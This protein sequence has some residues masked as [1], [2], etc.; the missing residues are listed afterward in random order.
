MFNT[1]ALIDETNP[2]PVTAGSAASATATIPFSPASSD[3]GAITLSG[4]AIGGVGVTAAPSSGHLGIKVSRDGGST[5]G[6]LKSGGTV[7]AIAAAAGDDLS[8]SDYVLPLIGATHI[9]FFN[10]DASGTPANQATAD[11]TLKYGLG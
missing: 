11:C 5:Y 10:C 4:K 1:S 3:S 9:K 8:L 7:V 2:L 6:I